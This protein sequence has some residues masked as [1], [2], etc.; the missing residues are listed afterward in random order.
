[1]TWAE[2]TLIEDATSR[3]DECMARAG[4]AELEREEQEGLGL[5]GTFPTGEEPSEDD[6]RSQLDRDVEA[7]NRRS[8]KRILKNL[9]LWLAPC[10]KPC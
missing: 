8:D 3:F 5:G 10:C 4:Q 2:W 9:K 1:M 6:C 7:I